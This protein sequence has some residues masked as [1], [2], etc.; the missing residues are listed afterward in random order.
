MDTMNVEVY[1]EILIEH[2]R[3]ENVG[4]KLVEKHGEDF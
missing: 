2:S 4:E 1:R 3:L